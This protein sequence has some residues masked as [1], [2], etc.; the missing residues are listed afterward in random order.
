MTVSY[1]HL[2]VYKRQEYNS[3]SYNNIY[4]LKYQLLCGKY[5][6]NNL[7][8]VSDIVNYKINKSSVCK[9]K[10]IE[11]RNNCN[12]IGIRGKMSSNTVTK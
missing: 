3:K 1:T 12:K 6:R 8:Y 11:C 4:K 2:D 10:I 7:K 5:K 9:Q